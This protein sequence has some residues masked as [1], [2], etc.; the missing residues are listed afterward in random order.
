MDYI[1]IQYLNYLRYG[2]YNS[3]NTVQF[4]FFFSL[5]TIFSTMKIVSAITNTL[6]LTIYTQSKTQDKR[7]TKQRGWGGNIL[8]TIRAM[9]QH[10][11]EACPIS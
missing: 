5:T 9:G 1:T 3:Y 6:L 8:R 10:T 2:P 11:A 4:H 7:N